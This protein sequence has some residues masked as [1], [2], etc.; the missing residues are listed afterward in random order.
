VF[1]LALL[2]AVLEVD[3]GWGTASVIRHVS[4]LMTA[5]VTSLKCHASQ[6]HTDLVR[7]LPG[8]KHPSWS[9]LSHIKWTKV[10]YYWTCQMDACHNR[11]LE[12]WC[13]MDT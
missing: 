1:R 3:V 5:A 2:H 11:L 4:D 8:I 6:V 7:F 10:E 13:R 9:E 12:W